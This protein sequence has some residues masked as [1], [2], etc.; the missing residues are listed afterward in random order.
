MSW[1]KTLDKS[2]LVSALLLVALGVFVVAQAWDW[3]YLTKDGPGPGFFPLWIGI[4]LIVLAATLIALHAIGA[5]EGKTPEKTNWK[6]VRGVLIGWVGLMIAA[7]LLEPAGFVASFV[8]LAAFLVRVVF[9]QSWRSTIIVSLASAAGIWL[10][11]VKLLQVRLPAGPW[12][13]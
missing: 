6:G 2:D 9:R 13:F 11:F 1:W 10:V 3:P 5:A 8:L 4:A 7:A 12:G